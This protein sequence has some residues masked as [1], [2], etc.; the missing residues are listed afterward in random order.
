MA[1]L[2]QFLVAGVNGAESGTALFFLRGTSSGAESVMWNEF[3]E[4][5]QPASHIVQLDA[6]GSAEVYVSAY[7]D[8]QIRDSGNTLL[9]T[10]TVG[11]A[12]TTT[13]VQSASFTGTDYDG[14]PA[15]TAGEPVTLKAILD[16]WLTSAGATDWKVL[17]NGVPANLSSLIAPFV[18]MFVNVKDPQYG[19][20][21]NGVTD[22]TTAITAAA[23]AITSAG[24][25]ILFFPPG[26]YQVSALSLSC[27]DAW[28]MGCGEEASIIR[29]ASATTSLLTFTDNTAAS[30]KR[31]TGIGF[32]V[33]AAHT[34][35]IDIENDQQLT[36]DNCKFD[37]SNV[38]EA[39]IRRIDADGESNVTISNCA[40]VDVAGLAAIMNLSDDGES[41]ITVHACRLVLASNF[42]GAAIQGPD[43]SVSQSKFDGSAITSG[44]YYHI[45][46][47]SNETAGKFLGN[48]IGNKFS[49]GGSDG[50]AFYL[51]GI[52]SGSSFKE[53]GNEFS[54]FVEPADFT[55][56]G[57]IYDNSGNSASLLNAEVV[58]GSRV[59][60]TIRL[61]TANATDVMLPGLAYEIIV[62][63]F[64]N[65]DTYTA[66][67][68]GLAPL[69][70]PGAH[71]FLTVINSSGQINTV[72]FTSAGAG[73]F[74][75][76]AVANS[77]K[78]MS[79]FQNVIETAGSE[80]MA[81]YSIRT[82]A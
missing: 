20:V 31:V 4:L 67:L 33:T 72:T 51:D 75:Q 17:A 43:F 24:G 1:T 12:A 78:V 59:G 53:Q 38:S 26:T 46:A 19:A 16:K 11:N 21:G 65:D 68:S 58:L 71:L 7:V 42:T 60:K 34:S 62:L 45:D 15:N 22:D 66:V 52:A 63:T 81:V 49:D 35:L 69:L 8:I 14:S 25:G 32:A 73:S 6:N 3:E 39:C 27:V 13:E 77:L 50:F 56:S 2:V 9:R 36:I 47:G 29:S 30:S 37:G 5:T 70:P 74:N 76:L 10:V 79:H 57:H 80:S 55:E 40:F 54:G 61:T 44:I 41:F 28:L 23:A 82:S 64:T 18:G 48:F